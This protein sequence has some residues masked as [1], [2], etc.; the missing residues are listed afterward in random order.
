MTIFTTL[1]ARAGVK[2]EP[3]KLVV[4]M[5]EGYPNSDIHYN[6]RV[7]NP[8]PY[9]I[10]VKGEAIHPYGLSKN[11]KRIPDLSWVE[12]VPETLVVPANSSKEFEMF[13]NVP[14][15]EKQ[16]HYNESW[17]VWVLITPKK[18]SKIEGDQGVGTVIHVRSA[19]KVLIS[20]PPGENKMSFPHSF[21]IILIPIVGFIVLFTIL[22]FMKK[23]K[24]T[25]SSKAAIYYIKDKKSK[26][27]S[28]EM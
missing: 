24:D 6:I 4:N 16:L 3:A 10:K 28:R 15:K 7:T 20:T 14:G 5:S 11:Y 2:V 12:I 17:E 22:L 13:I 18:S 21:Y 8:Y 25:Q 9:D 1:D 23:K 26:T 27:D 19:V